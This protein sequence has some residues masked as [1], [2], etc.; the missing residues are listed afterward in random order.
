MA[1]VVVIVVG[2]SAVLALLGALLSL[3]WQALAIAFLGLRA[4]GL[5]IAV[6]GVALFL[7]FGNSGGK[8][9]SVPKEPPAVV[10]QPGGDPTILAPGPS[11]APPPPVGPVGGQE[12]D[13]RADGPR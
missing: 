9:T 8:E 4:L 11:F 12:P 5:M 6:A 7:A 10:R 3:I 2:G 1:L 13:P